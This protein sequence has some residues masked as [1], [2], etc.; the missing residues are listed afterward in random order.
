MDH[1]PI[2]MLSSKAT[3]N[4]FNITSKAAKDTA[5]EVIAFIIV[6]AIP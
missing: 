5:R 4:E 6:G 1:E 3:A 2:N